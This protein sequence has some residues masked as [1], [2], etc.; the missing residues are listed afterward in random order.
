MHPKTH[1]TALFL[2]ITLVLAS[3]STM[4]K[5]LYSMHTPK[6]MDDQSIAYYAVKYNIPSADSYAIDTAY[7]AFLLAL[8][9]AL[10][11]A[12][13]HNHLQP[14]QA[15]YYDKTGNLLSFQINCNAGGFPNLKWDS[16]E[17]FSTFPP[18][19]QTPPDRV[20]PLSTLI[21]HLRP[22]AQSQRFSTENFDYVV[23]VYW[24]RFMG[25]Q[26]KRLVH[27]VQE[28]SKL[29]TDKKVKILYVNADNI[30]VGQ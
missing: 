16:H 2:A 4:V 21:S 6:P 24:C 27:F 30:F 26:S 13:T 25:R 14:L 12:Q 15:L 3:C 10:Y 8:D 22:L 29:A 7:S 23:V 19:Q 20:L 28:N 18:K 5:G 9:T 11:K 1:F 17:T